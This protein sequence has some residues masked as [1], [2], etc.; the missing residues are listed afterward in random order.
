MPAIANGFQVSV[1]L[2]DLRLKMELL[3]VRVSTNVVRR[4]L[5]AGAGV[6]RDEARLR[7]PKR[8]GALKKSIIAETDR[9]GSSRER[10]IANVK[11]APRSFAVSPKGRAKAVSAKVQKARGKRT[12][13]GELYPRAYAHLVEFGTR[14]HQVG[15]G[16]RLSKGR[17]SGGSHPGT[18]P[19]PFLRPAYDVK[20][21]EAKA[22]IERV[23]RAELQRE[24]MKLG[25]STLRSAT[26]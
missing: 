25:R 5:L 12:V 7:A 11:I 23:I 17:S 18:A 4:G 15:K 13:R 21:G 16:S 2:R 24:L 26:A 19:Q 22:V 14:P 3:G 1:D 10:L 6:I 9:K 8:T 20:N